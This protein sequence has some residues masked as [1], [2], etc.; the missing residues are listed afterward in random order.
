MNSWN[1]V[2][3]LHTQQL[4]TAH[5]KIFLVCGV[6]TSC[7]LVTVFTRSWLVTA[8]NY[9]GPSAS[10]L[11]YSLDDGWLA[12]LP[13]WPVSRD[14]KHPSGARDQFLL[15]M[16]LWVCWCGMTSLMRGW[17]CCLH[18]SQ[19]QL[20]YWSLSHSFGSDHIE[21]TASN[22]SFVLTWCVK[23]GYCLVKAL[24][25]L[26]VD[27]FT[28]GCLATYVSATFHVTVSINFYLSDYKASLF[29]TLIFFSWFVSWII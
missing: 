19:W 20:S 28:G 24:L 22:S 16:Q 21:N 10:M 26:V 11:M 5:T 25:F 1:T 6:F 4:T 3:N 9:G 17:V 8:A 2:T 14:V 13:W 23:R 18:C 15:V 27:M 7:C 12:T 29:R